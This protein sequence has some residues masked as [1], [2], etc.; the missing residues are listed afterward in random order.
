MIGVFSGTSSAIVN[1]T[2]KT[3]LSKDEDLQGEKPSRDAD[4]NIFYSR[5]VKSFKPFFTLTTM[6]VLKPENKNENQ[7][8]YEKS[9]H[10]GRPLFAIMQSNGELE[11]KMETI[12]RRLL[13][14][15]GKQG[16]GWTEHPES[17]LSVLATRVQMGSTNINVVSDLVAKGYA[18]LT[19]VTS[20]FAT[21]VYMPDPVCARL[22]MCLMDEK[23]SLSENKGKSKKWWSE[24]FKTLY[25]TGLCLPDKGSVGEVL[26][27]LYFLFCADECRKTIVGNSKYNTFSVPLEDWINSLLLIEE[28]PGIQES[29]SEPAGTQKSSAESADKQESSSDPADSRESISETKGDA[30]KQNSTTIRVNFIQVCRDYT[31][32]PWSGLADQG[33]LKNL[34]NAGTAFYTYPGCELIDFVAPTVITTP[35]KSPTYG[36]VLVSIK[37]RLY[38][39]PGDAARE[40]D[41][42]KNKANTLKLKSTLCV[43]FVFG[44]TSESDDNHYTCI[45][46]DVV[47]KLKKGEN[48][49][50][51]LRLPLEDRFGFSKILLEMT[52]V[53]QQSEILSSHS[54]LRA[55][56]KIL[57]AKLALRSSGGE[58]F[59]KVVEKF[60]QLMKSLFPGENASP[61]KNTSPAKKRRRKGKRK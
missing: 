60:D 15:T 33:F 52:A 2:V 57:A 61:T 4:E 16:F 58:I 42:I 8:E 29:R 22:A 39:P 37:S 27:A 25:S 19:G 51:V 54:F 17:W 35:N 44:Q 53:T 38:F 32:S 20:N 10:Y 12:L 18:N 34:Y 13:L 30:T 40:C 59:R 11:E 5:G 3:D 49:P 43:V 1:Y 6:A 31:R 23:W 50:I 36:S 7:S 24:A 45:S 28:T 46:S 26:T 21:F 9:I 48:V 55:R 47:G 56:S 14:S 41:K